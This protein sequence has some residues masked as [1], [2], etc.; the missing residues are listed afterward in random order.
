ME[1][2]RMSF[3]DD[4]RDETGL[5]PWEK[6]QVAEQYVENGD[7]GGL[8]ELFSSRTNFEA[9]EVLTILKQVL[10]KTDDQNK[11]LTKIAV[12]ISNLHDQGK[13]NEDTF[14]KLDV[15]LKPYFDDS[16]LEKDY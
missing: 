12:S 15:F 5:T 4:L 16:N 10:K 6:L 9:K 8:E 3:E 1:F 14:N 11:L 13:I 7:L 2:D